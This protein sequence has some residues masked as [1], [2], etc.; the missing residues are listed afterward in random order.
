VVILFRNDDSLRVAA[1]SLDIDE[2][3]RD[4]LLKLAQPK[5]ILDATAK[6]LIKRH[7]LALWQKIEKEG[8]CQCPSNRREESLTPRP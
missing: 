2:G 7:V 5:A 4:Y 6:E 1:S 3:A 8:F